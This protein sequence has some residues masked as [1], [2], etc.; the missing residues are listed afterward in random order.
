MASS[1]LLLALSALGF[2]LLWGVM[3]ANNNLAQIIHA[4]QK[5]QYPNDRSLRQVYTGFAPFDEAFVIAVAFF[6]LL[7]N[8]H[9]DASRWLFFDLCC[10]LAA[11]STWVLIESRR[12]GVRNLFLRQ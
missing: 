8:R 10:T 3:L 6:D 2:A 5:G 7:T 1:R 4:T 12:R 11:M 9:A